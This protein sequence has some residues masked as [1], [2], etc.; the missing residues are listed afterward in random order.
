MEKNIKSSRKTIVFL[1]NQFNQKIFLT[2][3][4]M[5]QLQ[6]HSKK[7]KILSTVNTTMGLIAT[8]LLVHA[9]IDSTEMMLNSN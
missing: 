3:E 4:P 7:I 9:V 6:N 5:H 8:S 1:F 2:V